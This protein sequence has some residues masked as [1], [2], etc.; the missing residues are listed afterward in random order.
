VADS[1][2]DRG[3]TRRAGPGRRE[4][5]D[6][7]RR[8]VAASV[9][10]GAGAEDLGRVTALVDGAVR[11]LEEAAPPTPSPGPG[12]GPD[13]G[14]VDGGD[15]S[16]DGRGRVATLNADNMQEAMAFDVV[17]GSCNPVALP[18]AIEFD[19][20][21]A[22]GHATYSETFEGAPG[23]VHGAVLAGAFDVVLTAAN[24]IAGAAG[25]TR[26]LT[27]R[28]LRPTTINRPLVYE[29]EVTAVDGRRIRSR[30]RIVQDGVVTVEAEGEF[31][32][33]DPAA[34]EAM[35]R[36]NDAAAGGGPPSGA[37]GRE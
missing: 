34:I 8:L 21:R 5:A 14:P 24:V 11:L 7:V 30:G 19:G 35:H 4:L 16:T 29:A 32:N 15:A 9:T 25:P 1:A 22:I 28:Y 36:R 26:S 10:T 27:L 20:P 31:V 18:V 13:P 37:P 23:W 3:T 33:L 12:P 2:R 6:A 17:I